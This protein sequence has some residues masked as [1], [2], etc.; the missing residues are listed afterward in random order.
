MADGLMIKSR[1][2]SADQGLLSIAILIAIVL[3][4]QLA[5]HRQSHRAAYGFPFG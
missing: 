2:V 3:A 5:A 1:H 4:K